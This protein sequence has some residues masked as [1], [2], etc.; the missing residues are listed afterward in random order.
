M[1]FAESGL[2]FGAPLDHN[3][4]NEL[5]AK[6]W[7]LYNLNE[8]PCETNNLA[9]KERPRLI[10]MIGM[11]PEQINGGAIDARADVFALGVLLYEYASGTHPFSGSTMFATIGRITHSEAAPL[12][13]LGVHV[14]PR[15]ERVIRRCLAKAPADR[16]ASAADVVA[17]LND[18]PPVL[19]APPIRPPAITWWHIHQIVI[20][21]LYVSWG[22]TAARKNWALQ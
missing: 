3:K 6:G 9:D 16:F 4:L 21:V 15:V 20:F 22:A 2:P 17:A 7:E 13:T 14:D 18:G 10:E 8:D 5:D 12:S 19:P 1:S 11:A